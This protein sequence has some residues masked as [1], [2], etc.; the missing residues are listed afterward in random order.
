MDSTQRRA[1]SL[2][3]LFI[4]VQRVHEND[5]FHVVLPQ[6]FTK[7]LGDRPTVFIEIIQRVGCMR[8]VERP[9]TTKVTE[10]VR[11]KH[12]LEGFTFWITFSRRG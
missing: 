5:V 12:V 8:E 3:Q 1:T 7:P 6:I 2:L 4:K 10:Q 9:D 11:S